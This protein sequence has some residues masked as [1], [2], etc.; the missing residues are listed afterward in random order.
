[1]KSRSDLELQEN[2]PL[3]FFYI[4]NCYTFILLKLLVFFKCSF[5]LILI[6]TDIEKRH[7]FEYKHGYIYILKYYF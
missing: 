1:M 3:T 7:K 4:K 2:L 5:F 6:D